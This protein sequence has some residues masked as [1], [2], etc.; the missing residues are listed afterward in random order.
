[1]N[2][3]MVREA[4]VFGGAVAGAAWGYFVGRIIERRRWALEVS[5]SL[6][7]LERWALKVCQGL[8]GLER[9][10]MSLGSAYMSQSSVWDPSEAKDVLTDARV[11]M[12]PIKPSDG[13]GLKRAISR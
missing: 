9:S 13:R 8:E 1:M 6:E 4:L 7:A 12:L 5:P 3:I 11:R 2:E 10:L